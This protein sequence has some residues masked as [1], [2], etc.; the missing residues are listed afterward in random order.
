M[1]A[2]LRDAINDHPL[3]VAVG[4]VG[5]GVVGYVAYQ[6]RRVTV[7]QGLCITSWPP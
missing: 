4:A 3:A 2:K 1:F 5:V 6:V 7:L